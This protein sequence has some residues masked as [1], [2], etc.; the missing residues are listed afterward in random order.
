MGLF[1][2]FFKKKDQASAAPEGYVPVQPY[3]AQPQFYQDQSG[4]PFGSFALT[5]DTLTLLPKNP[6]GQYAIGGEPVTDFRLALISTSLDDMVG[7][8][9]Y[10]DALPALEALAVQETE[11]YFLLPPLTLEQLQ[12]LAA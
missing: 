5:E 1:D 4:S 3:V 7:V 9:D 10:G 12:E 6:H 2:R 11:T 8:L